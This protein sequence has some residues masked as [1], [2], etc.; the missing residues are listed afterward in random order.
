MTKVQNPSGRALTL[1][2]WKILPDGRCVDPLGVLGCCLPDS[3]AYSA[4]AK[5]LADQGLLK[6]YGYNWF[7]EKKPVDAEPVASKEEQ[8]AL[9]KKGSKKLPESADPEVS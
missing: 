4:R 6:I 5:K 2:R 8:K 7:D 1:S 3:I 9:K